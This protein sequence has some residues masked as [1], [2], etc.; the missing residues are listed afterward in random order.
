MYRRGVAWSL[1]FAGRYDEAI[2]ELEAT[3]Q[4]YPQH[5]PARTLL[6][7]A[8]VQVG[9]Y[10]EGIAE[11]E[12]VGDSYAAM[13]AHAYVAAGRTDEAER[14]IADLLAGKTS[15]PTL[16]FEVALIYVALEEPER[17]MEWL[18]RGFGTR[19]PSMVS[20][21]KD[22][23]LDPLRDHPRFQELLRRMKFPD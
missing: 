16:P 18:E 12:E 13:L 4:K 6:G 3:L 15:D 20:L 8:Y 11:L 2:E 9:R 7:R 17:A 21:K 14:A 19:D 22:P 23:R 10:D 5:T 1:F